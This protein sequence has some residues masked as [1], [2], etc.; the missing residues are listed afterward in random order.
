MKTKN[1][2]QI[3]LKKEQ[4]LQIAGD[5]IAKEGLEHLSIRKIAAKMNQTPGI[6]YHY[7]KDKDE[8]ILE[9][10]E[11]GYG[12]ILAI[13]REPNNIPDTPH[14]LKETLKNYLLTMIQKEELFLTLM[15]SSNEKIQEKVSILENGI[16][17]KR[18]SISA[19][20]MTIREGID[21]KVFSCD[22]IE[23][24]AQVIWCAA[25]GLISR[26][27]IEKPDVFQRDRLIEAHLDMVLQS[28]A[29]HRQN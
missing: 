15:R 5:I 12:E 13:L 6:L 1:E 25:Y 2:N 28:L 8:I 24:R 23:L 20:C 29:Y 22:G 26:I 14:R 9:L 27:V 4:I 7:F 11:Q 21:E 18:G 16:S 10:T 17:E 19:L 3:K